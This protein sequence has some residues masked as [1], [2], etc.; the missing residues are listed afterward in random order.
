MGRTHILSVKFRNRAIF[1]RLS[2]SKKTVQ[3]KKYL[4]LYALIATIALLVGGRVVR[5]LSAENQRL[6]ANQ[7]ALVSCIEGLQTSLEALQ[8]RCRE[9]ERLH[10]RDADTIRSLGIRLRRVE[11]VAKQAT[12]TRFE[13]RTP[14]YDTVILRRDT[15]PLY[16]TLRRF[17][18]RDAWVSLEGELA[19]DT[20]VCRV[21]SV[22]TL[23]QIVHRVPRRFLFIRWG[24]KAIR[25]EIRSSNPHTRLVYADYVTISR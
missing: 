21:A 23:H 24:T 17:A 2:S 5:M 1:S 8:L 18:W 19:R 15:L 16:D 7:Y 14:L 13:V 22:D 6:T 11:Q 10:Q 4:F 9:Y 25:Q 20:L 3:M 12:A